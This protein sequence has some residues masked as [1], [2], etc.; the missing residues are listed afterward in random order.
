MWLITVRGAYWVG[1]DREDHRRVLIR[2]RRRDH[3][4]SLNELLRRLVPPERAVKIMR[5]PKFD[6]PYRA[7][8]LKAQF[9]CVVGVLAME[10]KYG[11]FK[12]AVSER[13]GPGSKYYKW[14][15]DCWSG[16]FNMEDIPRAGAGRAHWEEEFGADETRR[17]P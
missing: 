10:V 16:S 15:V 2:T 12:G 6:F 3:L 1:Q 9:L 13:H 17:S 5:T 7:Y 4:E 14:L 11:T 8:M